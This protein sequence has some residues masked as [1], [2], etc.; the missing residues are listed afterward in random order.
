M[1]DRLNVVGQG[2]SRREN[3]SE[4]EEPLQTKDNREIDH[5]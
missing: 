2:E 1:M 5:I 3:K 4:E